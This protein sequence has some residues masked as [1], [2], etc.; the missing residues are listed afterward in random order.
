MPRIIADASSSPETISRWNFLSEA[1]IAAVL[2]SIG[3]SSPALC[4]FNGLKRLDVDEP[5]ISD[6]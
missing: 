6:S 4:N 1:T 5:T 2:D 3:A